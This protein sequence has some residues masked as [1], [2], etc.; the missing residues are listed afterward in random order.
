MAS[1]EVAPRGSVGAVGETGESELGEGAFAKIES[2]RWMDEDEEFLPLRCE[3]DDMAGEEGVDRGETGVSV[4]VE[5]GGAPRE[6]E[7]EVGD[8]APPATDK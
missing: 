2:L 4:D 3:D 6:E 5:P 7:E 8:V 1:K